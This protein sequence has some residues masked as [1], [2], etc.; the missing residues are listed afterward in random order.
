MNN[1]DRHYL[2]LGLQRGA[3]QEEIDAAF[4][5]MSVK[6]HPDN[7][8]S[9]D[10]QMKFHEARQAY[11]ALSDT[12]GTKTSGTTA[13]TQQAASTGQHPHDDELDGIIEDLM[14]IP[15]HVVVA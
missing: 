8:S 13:G 6:Y 12:T 15:E 10:A 2:T 5:R 9:L 3:T 11:A 14:A 4:Q 1:H 7:D